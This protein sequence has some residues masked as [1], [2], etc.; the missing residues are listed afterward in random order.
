MNSNIDP[1][2]IAGKF[3]NA[4]N[5]DA[6]KDP[7]DNPY[8]PGFIVRNWFDGIPNTDEEGNTLKSS[9]C[10]MWQS[11][12]ISPNQA[13]PYT[14]NNIDIHKDEWGGGSAG[15]SWMVPVLLAAYGK[16]CAETNLL[17]NDYYGMYSD[18]WGWGIFYP[19]DANSDKRGIP[20]LKDWTKHA[21]GWFADVQKPVQ[22]DD[23]K[24]IDDPHSLVL[25]PGNPFAYGPSSSGG[26][27]RHKNT[28]FQDFLLNGSTEFLRQ[29][30]TGYFW[31]A[32][33]DLKGKDGGWTPYIEAFV[34]RSQEFGPLYP[35]F[36]TNQQLKADASPWVNNPGDMI[37][38]QNALYYRYP[39]W[40]DCKDN[41]TYWGWNEL[42]LQK[43][44]LDDA[45]HVDAM[46]FNLPSEFLGF[47]E[48]LNSCTD[49]NQRQK[50]KDGMNEQINEYKTRGCYDGKPVLFSNTIMR[51]KSDPTKGFKMCV[52]VGEK[53]IYLKD[54]TLQ[55]GWAKP[56]A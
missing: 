5:S 6:A 2:S 10:T 19:H 21:D 52:F 31:E 8:W 56:K 36:S 48:L 42:P 53:P 49:D 47:E 40:C 18:T 33:Y 1:H 13:Y 30:Y 15:T 26:A 17:F 28:D 34:Q 25:D 51:D 9:I 7:N 20:Q 12:I 14:R 37:S 27:G 41:R 54:Y 55:D 24:S 45:A 43:N 11:C 29:D 3:N 46:I 16:A 22:Y 35:G 39:D 23:G 32:N 4:L 38:L 50:I 44:L